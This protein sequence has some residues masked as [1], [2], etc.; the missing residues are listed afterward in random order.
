[1]NSYTSR[2]N[3]IYILRG[4][5]IYCNGFQQGDFTA[6]GIAGNARNIL[7]ARDAAKHVQGSSLQ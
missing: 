5:S 1:M 7:E 2:P 3:S 4:S 6:L